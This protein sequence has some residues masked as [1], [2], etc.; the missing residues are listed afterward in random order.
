M[1]DA[2]YAAL[3]PLYLQY[4]QSKGVRGSASGFRRWLTRNGYQAPGDRRAQK[5]LGMVTPRR[6][7][8]N[9]WQAYSA[10]GGVVDLQQ[11]RVDYEI[12]ASDVRYAIGEFIRENVRPVS[13]RRVRSSGALVG[14]LSIPDIHVGKL[15]W[16]PEVGENYDIKIAERTYLSAAGTLVEQ[17]LNSGV[18]HVIYVV[19]NDLL[20]VDN[21]DNATTKRTIQDADSRWQ[22]MFRRAKRMVVSVAEHLAHHVSVKIVVAPGNHDRVLSWALG[23]VIDAYFG[24]VEHVVVDNSPRYRKYVHIGRL[25]FGI[26]HGD[27]INQ[28]MLPTLM[29]TEVPEAWGQTRLREWYLGHFHRKRE[30]MTVAVHDQNGV[31]VRYLPS[32]SGPDRWH[33]ERGYSAV[34]SAE[35]HV[36]DADSGTQTTSFYAYPAE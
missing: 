13:I 32:L 19:G 29:A 3:V 18:G 34:R 8:V 31:R 25:L 28:S 33:Y 14:V 5:I 26:T 22:N 2:Q 9:R 20:H 15:G 10:D 6:V 23:E 7:R 24:N 4:A 21:F 35:A 27:G 1:D 16:G 11:H 30:L 12:G 17:L 36:Y